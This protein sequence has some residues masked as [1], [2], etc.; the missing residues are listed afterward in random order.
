MN[1]FKWKFKITWLRKNLG[2]WT[3]AHA[4]YSIWK[5]MP[6]N[7]LTKCN[8]LRGNALHFTRKLNTNQY[9][10]TLVVRRH[11]FSDM[12]NLISYAR[13]WRKNHLYDLSN[14]ACSCCRC[15]NNPRCS[16]LIMS[17]H[18]LRLKAA[19]SFLETSQCTYFTEKSRLRD[20]ERADFIRYWRRFGL[21]NLD[22]PKVFI[23][24]NKINHSYHQF[25]PILTKI[26]I[27]RGLL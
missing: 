22:K 15:H 21:K 27:N 20:V 11:S 10:K 23:K 19:E 8:M 7:H 13:V 5:V 25:Y 14:V 1:N 3:D 18:V 16:L 4:F 6:S 2:F 26:R 9:S 24:K 17:M 12:L